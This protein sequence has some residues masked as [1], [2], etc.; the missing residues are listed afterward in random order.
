MFAVIFY[1]FGYVLVEIILINLQKKISIYLFVVYCELK[2]EE[3]PVDLPVE[4]G[5]TQIYCLL[6][7]PVI[8]FALT[9]S[10][11]LLNFHIFFLLQE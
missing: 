6:L 1:I 7:L 9:N 10:K 3:L 2:R 8:L 11:S 4:H 5:V